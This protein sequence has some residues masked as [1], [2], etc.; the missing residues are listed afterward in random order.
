M[1]FAIFNRQT[2]SPQEAGGNYGYSSRE[3]F[4]TAVKAAT[5]R[6]DPHGSLSDPK[7]V[8]HRIEYTSYAGK[9]IF[10]Y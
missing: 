8:G 2:V 1:T 9:G 3:E 10:T 5:F 7:E 4:L 6:K